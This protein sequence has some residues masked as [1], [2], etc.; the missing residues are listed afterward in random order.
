MSYTMQKKGKMSGGNIREEEE[1]VRGHMSRG[2]M[3]GSRCCS[4]AGCVHVLPADCTFYARSDKMRSQL[5]R[6]ASHL[7]TLLI[8]LLDTQKPFDTYTSLE[9]DTAT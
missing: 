5:S 7:L 1:H 6:V 8:L 2:D 3:S 4:R 9:A